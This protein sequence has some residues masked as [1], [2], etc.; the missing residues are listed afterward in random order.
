[1][2]DVIINKSLNIL[3][4]TYN[5]DNDTFDR[6]KY[7]LELIYISIT[8]MIVIFCISIIFGLLK[9]TVLVI[10]FSNGLRTFAYGVHAKKSWHCHISSITVFVLLPFIFRNLYFSVFQKIFISIFC[11]ISYILFAPAD[12]HKR[13]IINKDHRKKLKLNALI[14]CSIYILMIFVSKYSLLNNMIILSM[15]VESFAINPI[16]YKLCGMPYNNYKTYQT[17]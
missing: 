3:C 15:I 1:M 5:Y 7:G 14:V 10:L 4:N 2:K 9:E 13:P 8:K 12:T 6:V 11:F 16:I 17:K